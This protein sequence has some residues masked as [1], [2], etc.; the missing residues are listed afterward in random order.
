MAGS[1]LPLVDRLVPGGLEK[2]LV[3]WSA[4]GLSTDAMAVRLQVDHGVDVTRE[5]VR[6]WLHHYGVRTVGMDEDGA[7]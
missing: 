4:E 3:R 2:C 5:T 6:R 1:L 7:A